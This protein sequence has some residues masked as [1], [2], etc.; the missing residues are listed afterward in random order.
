V[1]N[2][3]K[4]KY[5]IPS[6]RAKWWNYGNN[7]A[8]FVTICTYDRIHYFGQINNGIIGLSQ[9]G[10]FAWEC[11]NSIPEYFPFVELGGFIVMPNH[12]HGIII[13]NKS[14]EEENKTKNDSTSYRNKFGPQ[15]M[16]LASIIRGYKT[17]VTKM[18]RKIYPE[19]SWQARYHDYIIRSEKSHNKITNYIDNNPINWKEDKFY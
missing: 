7:A 17:G 13:I 6:A 11:W 15:S 19:F 8:Y 5:R 10:N 16:N 4:N 2:K 1:N 12:V 14:T 18:S 3:Y 9:I